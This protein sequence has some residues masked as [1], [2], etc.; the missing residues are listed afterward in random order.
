MNELPVIMRTHE[1]YGWVSKITEKLPSLKRQSLGRRLEDKT[2]EL[3]EILIMAKNA[4]RPTKAAYL[5]KATA[6]NE[7]V[8]FHLHTIMEQKLANETTLHQLLAKN[9]EIGRMIGGWRKSV[10]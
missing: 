1:L 5:I 10:Q 2:L 4:P 3:L 9:A 7:I 8:D 6:V